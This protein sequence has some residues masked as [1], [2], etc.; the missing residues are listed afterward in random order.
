MRIKICILM[1]LISVSI[2]SNSAFALDVSPSV[3][4]AGLLELNRTYEYSVYI[5]NR[6]TD[7]Y[8]LNLSI[9]QRA[10]Y[11]DGCVDFSPKEFEIVPGTRQEIKMHLNASA[12]YLGPGVHN[13]LIIPKVSEANTTGVKVVSVP[14]I[15]LKFMV[16]GDVEPMF[17]LEVFDMERSIDE[18]DT[19]HFS[20]IL[21][22]TGN[23]RVSAVPY[24]EIRKYGALI[25][26]ARGT[27]EVLLEPGS[28]EEV[29]F[30]YSGTLQG[31]NY[32]AQIF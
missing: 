1:F 19:L 21:N 27:T 12:C 16:P 26:I 31:G 10:K 23:V 32:E 7:I 6:D 29:E 14:V 20:M 22:N 9:T 24:V 17:A 4:D 8:D 11:L 30:S 13:L 3:V 15:S 5:I 28:V 2:V 25:D 18:G